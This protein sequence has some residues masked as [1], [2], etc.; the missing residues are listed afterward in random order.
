M[1]VYGSLLVQFRYPSV[2]TDASGGAAATG[3][4]EAKFDQMGRRRS[5]QARK[6]N[7][8]VIGS[9]WVSSKSRQVIS[10]WLR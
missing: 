8:N 7:S 3:L 4:R 9:E 2:S 5:K 1:P 10:R 6:P